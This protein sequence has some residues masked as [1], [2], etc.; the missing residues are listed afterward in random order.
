MLLRSLVFLVI[1]K[2]FSKMYKL[3]DQNNM[4]KLLYLSKEIKIIL[5]YANGEINC[6]YYDQTKIYKYCI[7]SVHAYSSHIL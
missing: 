3:Y 7:K 1:V 2:D 5:L 4:L 6:I